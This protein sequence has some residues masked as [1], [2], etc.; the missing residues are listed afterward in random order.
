M[1]LLFYICLIK[2]ESWDSMVSIA[3]MLEAGQSGVSML[4]AARGYLFCGKSTL[5]LRSTKPPTQCVLGALFLGV[6]EQTGCK[7]DHSH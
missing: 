6:V 1:C 5:A 7:D 3:T 4:V 2:Y